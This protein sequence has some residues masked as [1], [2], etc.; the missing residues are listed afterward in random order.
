MRSN[1]TSTTAAPKSRS[2]FR[3][4]IRRLKRNKL[5][6][7]AFFVIL[8]FIFVAI[9]ADVLMDY[10]NDVIAQNISERLQ[11]PSSK[12]IF[13][14]DA[15]G[16][17]LFKRI[18]YG[19]RASILVGV[20]AVSFS[21]VV[22]VPLG[23]YAGFKG[24]R[25]GE[26]IMRFSDILSAFPSIMLAL[27]IV[28]AFGQ[29][30]LNLI[31]AVGIS[32]VPGYIRITRAAVLTTKNTEYVEAARATGCTNTRVLFEHILPNC[33]APIIVQATMRVAN[34]IL[35]IASL[36]FLGLGIKPPTPEWGMILSSGRDLLLRGAWWVTLFPGI[37]IM[38]L[39][40][41]LNLLGDGLRDAL[42]PKLKR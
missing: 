17:D 13:G 39:V 1:E 16:R 41:C 21:L 33:F 3:E 10:E 4:A 9:F 15:V 11:A 22:G 14:T 8:L 34:A 29:S 36:S 42:D 35:S 28:A 27:C 38:L 40:L 23:A 20:V 12:H 19:T 31:I 2:Q 24:G 26:V 7:I 6:V 5:A 37:A 32:S 18:L 25:I 30:M